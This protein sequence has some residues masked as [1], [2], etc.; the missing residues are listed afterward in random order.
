M[1]HLRLL[2][3]LLTRVLLSFKLFTYLFKY[4]GLLSVE[5]QL[6][7]DCHCQAKAAVF[8]GHTIVPEKE[9]NY[10]SKLPTELA[11]QC[12]KE[13]TPTRR[14]MATTDWNKTRLIIYVDAHGECSWPISG[15]M[16]CIPNM[17]CWI[18]EDLS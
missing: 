7:K 13:K 2:C 6:H 17:I 8:S 18:L 5:M 12:Y 14:L 11:R 10:H 4:T 16:L 15:V 9:E 3:L 1:E